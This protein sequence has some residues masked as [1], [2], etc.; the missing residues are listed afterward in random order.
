MVQPTLKRPA[1]PQSISAPPPKKAPVRRQSTTTSASVA[2]RRIEPESA[3]AARPKREAHVPPPRD[4]QY[5]AE[6]PRKRKVKRRDDNLIEDLN[7]CSKVLNEL[8]AKRYKAF[9][10]FFYEPVGM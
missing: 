6:P 8:H 9:A 2:P 10:S 4:L 5:A 1:S 7:F 3:M